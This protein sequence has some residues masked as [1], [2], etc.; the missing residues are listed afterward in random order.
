MIF[1]ARWLLVCS[2]SLFIVLSAVAEVQ[3]KQETQEFTLPPID[4]SPYTLKIPILI[5]KPGTITASVTLKFAGVQSEK[6]VLVSLYQK[7]KRYVLTS[8]YYSPRTH[9]LRLQY[10]VGTEDLAAGG[11]F[12][13]SLTNYSHDKAAT[14]EVQITFPVAG[15][16]IHKAG[17]GPLPNLIITDIHLDERCKAIVTLKNSGTGALPLYFWKKHMPVLKLFQNGELW[18]EVDIRFFDY[19]QTLSPPGGEAVYNTGLKVIDSATI[20]AQIE[21]NSRVF[22]EDKTDNRKEVGVICE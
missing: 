5:S 19:R 14:G 1:N 21:T 6:T 16:I 8:K 18:G 3:A 2:L 10:E 4:G 11:E 7:N 17:D 13:L 15:E 9:G 22:E 12:Y 20:R